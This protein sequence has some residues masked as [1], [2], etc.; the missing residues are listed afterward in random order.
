MLTNLRSACRV[1]GQ[2]VVRKLPRSLSS[3]FYRCLHNGG[4]LSPVEEH[5]HLKPHV[6]DA[7]ATE[8]PGKPSMPED[9]AVDRLNAFFRSSTSAV[10][11][12][13]RTV[14]PE[15]VTRTLQ[16]MDGLFLIDHPAIRQD[17][18]AHF[19]DSPSLISSTEVLSE[20]RDPQRREEMRAVRSALF[21]HSYHVSR[22]YFQKRVY[23]RGL[24]E[25]S[26]VCQNDCLYCGIR[27]NQ[28]DIHRYTMSLDSLVDTAMTAFNLDMRSVMLQ[29]GEIV[30]PSRITYLTRAIRRI[31]ELSIAKDLSLDPHKAF[32]LR[33]PT[34]EEDR[35]SGVISHFSQ[36]LMDSLV[37]A[38]SPL[39]DLEVDTTTVGGENLPESSDIRVVRE[40]VE[41]AVASVLEAL[42]NE[43]WTLVSRHRL[44]HYVG[45]GIALSVGE[46][47]RSDYQQLMDAGAVRYLLRIESSNPDLFAQLHPA[48][49]RHDTR[50]EC[51]RTLKEMGYMIGTGVMIGLPGQRFED[52]GRDTEF[53]AEMGADMIGMGPYITQD[54]TPVADAWRSEYIGVS[55]KLQMMRMFELTTSMVALCRI[56]LPKVNIA[57]TTAMQ[58]IHPQGREVTLVRGANVLMP[59]ITPREHRANYVLYEGKPCVNDEPTQCRV[60]LEARLRSIGLESAPSL[61]GDPLS[62]RLHATAAGVGDDSGSVAERSGS[63]S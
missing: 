20:L 48:Q 59:I 34:E 21:A 14:H 19:H 1:A 55:K 11:G 10:S 42:T 44:L 56:S 30:H 39:L 26:N 47:S 18:Q 41:R 25:F 9:E 38:L 50:V 32:L 23:Y 27:K 8:V 2:S 53:F 3:V 28:P 13:A 5:H 37:S 36:T 35:G 4:I 40:G 57:A 22:H 31:R 12:E 15:D 62:F 16:V 49:Q 51:L 52:L 43:E 46:L 63:P 29:A 17:K 58:A 7:I 45:L 61:W 6:N 54:N 33:Q 60:C 24:I